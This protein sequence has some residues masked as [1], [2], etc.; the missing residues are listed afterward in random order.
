MVGIQKSTTQ[1]LSQQFTDGR[2]PGA[3]KANQ[4]DIVG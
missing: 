1:F 4:K 2:L 3:H